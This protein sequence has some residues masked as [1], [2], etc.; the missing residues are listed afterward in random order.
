MKVGEDAD[1]A[2]A[3]A[4]AERKRILS[5][6]QLAMPGADDIIAAAIADPTVTAGATALKI[7]QTQNAGRLRKLRALQ[8]DVEVDPTPRSLPSSEFDGRTAAGR[9]LLGTVKRVQAE[10]EAIAAAQADL[11]RIG[12]LGGG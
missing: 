12:Q 7:L 4:A 2:Q 8:R 10:Q 9:S 3:A 11:G 1:I 6:Q 5:I